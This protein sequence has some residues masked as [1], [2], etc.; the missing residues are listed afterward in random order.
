MIPIACLPKGGP[1]CFASEATAI[2]PHFYFHLSN[3]TGDTRDEEGLDLPDVARARAHALAA[4]RAIMREELGRGLIDLDGMI[5][6]MDDSDQLVMDVGFA[7]AVEVRYG[8]H[9]H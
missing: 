4:I 1:R 2:M 3:G 8:N 6:I 7:E 5:H 9:R